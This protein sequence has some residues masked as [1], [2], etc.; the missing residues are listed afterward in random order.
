MAGIVDIVQQTGT[1]VFFSSHIID[2]VERV[3]DWIGILHEGRLI[4][5]STLDDLKQSIRRVI[6][7]FPDSAPPVDS[8]S[9]LQQ[10]SEGRQRELI[11]KDFSE[12]NAAHLRAAGA[13]EVQ[14]Q[15]CSL[16]DIFIAYVRTR[17]AV[18]EV[19]ES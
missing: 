5:Q 17:P 11:W 18:E 9:I 12:A 4:V 14:V 16:E 2:D 1:T 15:A 3:A 8:P 19:A 13:T 7:T 6:A 10:S